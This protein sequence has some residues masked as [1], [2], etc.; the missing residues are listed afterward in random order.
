MGQENSK[1]ERKGKGKGTGRQG[2]YRSGEV[3]VR[4]LAHGGVGAGAEIVIVKGWKSPCG[5]WG[6]RRHERG[7]A[8]WS[9]HEQ[10]GG[11]AIGSACRINDAGD[12]ARALEARVDAVA[13][14]EPGRA[15]A[16]AVF[17]LDGAPEPGPLAND[18]PACGLG[19]HDWALDAIA[20][21][22]REWARRGHAYD[23]GAL[24]ADWPHVD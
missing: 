1:S 24:G 11:W 14:R 19:A 10:A 8:P 16:D 3:R 7:V 22:V 23:L 4:Q 15:G 13:K 6:T 18:A 2:W 9:L 12:L 5:R 17:C 20:L 21:P